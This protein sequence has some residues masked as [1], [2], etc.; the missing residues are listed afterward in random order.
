M[1]PGAFMLNRK[2]LSILLTL[3]LIMGISASGIMAEACLCGDACLHG[4]QNR[5]ETRAG[6]TFHKRCSETN[7]KS[8]NVENGSTLKA[9]NFSGPTANVKTLR[10]ALIPFISTHRHSNNSV[11]QDLSSPFQVCLEYQS[12]PPYLR[13]LSLLF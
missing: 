8:C 9:A 7:C 12:L 10:G 4:L 5:V 3:L 6:V 1:F 11:P 2:A 13:N